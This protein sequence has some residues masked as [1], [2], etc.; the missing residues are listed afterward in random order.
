MERLNLCC[1]G[2]ILAGWE[3]HDADMD[4][5]KPLSLPDNK[6]DFILIEHGAEHVT[7]PE[8]FRLFQECYRILKQG[9]RLRICVPILDRLSKE[10]AIDVIMNHGHQVVYTEGLIGVLLRL[11]GFHLCYDT[12]STHRKECDGHWRVIGREK[13]DLET[14]RIEAQKGY[15]PIPMEIGGRTT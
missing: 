11:A 4:I 9:G 10:A 3:N 13:D 12:E 2:N 8:G 6:Y 14:L 7:Q 15:T 1:G 5:S